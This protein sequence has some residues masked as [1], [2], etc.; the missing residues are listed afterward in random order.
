MMKSIILLTLF[1]LSIRPSF[2]SCGSGFQKLRKGAKI[3]FLDIGSHIKF[4]KDIPLPSYEN[5]QLIS[6][7]IWIKY[8]PYK[9]TQIIKR[10]TFKKIKRVNATY[11]GYILIMDNFHPIY[12]GNQYPKYE[13]ETVG[14]LEKA[15]RHAFMV[16]KKS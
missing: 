13:I 15:S 14:M 5:T 11:N 1:I 2:S 7:N 6:K 3:N 9:E 16:C 12:I 8:Q 10:G 4:I